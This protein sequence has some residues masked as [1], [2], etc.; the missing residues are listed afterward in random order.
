[1]DPQTRH[2]IIGVVLLC[3][4]AALVTPVIFRSP[5]QV[6]VALDMDLPP[7]PDVEPI[8]L[9]PVVTDDEIEQADEAIDQARED[10]AEA[11]SQREEQFVEQQKQA[12]KIASQA[13][14]NSKPPE[15]VSKP[16][17]TAA[18]QAVPSGW[19]VQLA[20]LSSKEG[21]A[22]LEKRLRDAK[23]SAYTRASGSGADRIYRVYVGPELERDRVEMDRNRLAGDIRF[24]LEGIVVPF[25]L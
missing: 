20:A 21:A 19:S 6:R 8:S 4:L 11:A 23:Y 14:A 9:S 17:E 5:D 24:K 13:K 1:M 12:A 18:Q 16:T 7:P 10:I 3:V 22:A 2:R 25:T 15:K